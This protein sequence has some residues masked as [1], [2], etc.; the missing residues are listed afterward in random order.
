MTF[1]TTLTVRTRT[2]SAV[3]LAGVLLLVSGCSGQA[4]QPEE[5]VWVMTF[6]I[7][8]ASPGDGDN[9]WGNRSDWV[10]SIID[11]SGAA[12]IGLQ[13]V[14][15]GQL[16]D[17]MA[18]QTRLSHVGVGRDDGAEKGEYSPILYDTT[19]FELIRWDTKW[20][21]MAPDSTGSVGWDAALPRIA[22]RAWLRDR[23]SGDTMHVINTHFDHRGEQA[24]LESARL[25]AD[26]AATGDVAMGDFNF[27][28]ET[29]PWEAVVSRGL[30]DAG[31][32]PSD[33]EAESGTFRT[34]DPDSDT[35]VRIDYVF[36]TPAWRAGTYRVLDPVRDGAYPSDHLPVVV[37]L[38]RVPGS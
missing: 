16:L 21:S 19:R 38:V 29:A 12:V 11:T 17:I 15:H 28:P 36:H 23:V 3:T 33:P 1:L 14:T 10:A 2:I 24:R 13:E 6:N 34:F 20:L 22:T 9:V 8:W 27:E 4:P 32:T 31:L 26:W 37:D 7:R 25:I 35:S 5:S 30:I 18:A